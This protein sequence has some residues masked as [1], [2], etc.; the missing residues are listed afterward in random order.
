MENAYRKSILVYQVV[1]VDSDRFPDCLSFGVCAGCH[2]S[3]IDTGV[4]ICPFFFCYYVLLICFTASIFYFSKYTK[5]SFS[6]LFSFKQKYIS[7]ETPKYQQHGTF[8]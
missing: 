8:L 6:H 7:T 2:F 4:F 3:S 5:F 1:N